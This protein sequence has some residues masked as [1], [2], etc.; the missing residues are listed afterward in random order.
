M[1]DTPEIIEEKAVVPPPAP[2]PVKEEPTEIEVTDAEQEA[3]DEAKPEAKAFDPKTDKVEFSTPEQQE[4]F[5]YMYKQTKM[6]DSRNQMLTN[7]LQEQQKQLDDLRGRFQ[8]TDSASAEALLMGKIKAARDAG[9]DLAEISATKELV[10][11]QVDKK[12]SEKVNAQPQY[13][14][15][16]E[17]PVSPEGEKFAND[18][19]MAKDNTGQLVRPWMHPS[20]PEHWNVKSALENI[21]FK[22]QDDPYIVQKSLTELDQLMKARM[23]QKAPP[24]AAPQPQP[25]APNPLQGTNL[26]NQHPRA[27]IKMTRAELDIARKLGVDPKRYA[28]TRDAQK[29]KK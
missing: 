25:R 1:T 29:G 23:T 2:E 15:V 24:A 4:K 7:L 9:D 26:T 28:A 20:H 18:Y 27:T 22:Y 14:P 6:S 8:K 10:D 19:V 5:N 11:F 3:P 13:Q 17:T 21:A 16:E 12:I